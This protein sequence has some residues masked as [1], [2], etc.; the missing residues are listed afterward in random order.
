MSDE[1]TVTFALELTEPSRPNARR[2]P[3][4]RG[5]PPW[6]PRDCDRELTPL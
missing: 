5:L 6:R 4:G 2:R 3:G 1:E